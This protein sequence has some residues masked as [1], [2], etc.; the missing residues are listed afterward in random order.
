[1]YSTNAWLNVDLVLTRALP[2]GSCIKYIG[3]SSFEAQNNFQAN[4]AGNTIF[5]CKNMH[6]LQRKAR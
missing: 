4:T 3:L 2:Y 1:M 5:S 6:V